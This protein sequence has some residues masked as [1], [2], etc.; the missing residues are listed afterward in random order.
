[1]TRV[2]KRRTASAPAPTITTVSDRYPYGGVR[3]PPVKGDPD[4]RDPKPKPTPKQRRPR[5][6]PEEPYPE[7]GAKK[8]QP[9]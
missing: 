6:Q 5:R 3:S 9:S 1:M 2:K 7:P 8:D 4:V